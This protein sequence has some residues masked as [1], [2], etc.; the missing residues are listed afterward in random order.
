MAAIGTLAF[1]R[2]K[3]V[4]ALVEIK[5][6]IGSRHE[7]GSVV[8][9][10]AKPTESHFALEIHLA[11]N[12]VRIIFLMANLAYSWVVSCSTSL[13]KQSET[14]VLETLG[15]LRL[16][17]VHTLTA[18]GF[19]RQ[20]S[21]RRTCPARSFVANFQYCAPADRP[22]IRSQRSDAI[23]IFGIVKLERFFRLRINIIK[24]GTYILGRIGAVE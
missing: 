3:L 2:R 11:T 12:S 4:Q 24:V 1:S 16:G 8:Q 7:G 20:R 18:Q 9:A 21:R 17:R 10:A 23:H 15:K 5:L 22:E 19:Y 6:A 14:L 13:L